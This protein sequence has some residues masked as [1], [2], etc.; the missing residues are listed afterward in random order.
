MTK[1]KKPK[2]TQTIKV[3][4]HWVFPK[5]VKGREPKAYYV[6][7]YKYE[8]KNKP[9]ASSA[10][11]KKKTL[12]PKPIRYVNGKRYKLKER[13]HSVGSEE[14]VVY[15]YKIEALVEYQRKYVTDYSL[16]RSAVGQNVIEYY[17]TKFR[18]TIK[19]STRLF[20]Q[21]I[22]ILRSYGH[23]ITFLAI[24]LYRVWGY[25]PLSEQ[26]WRLLKSFKDRKSVV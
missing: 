2:T 15:T 14:R 19:E 25:G 6:K 26:H 21:E 18:P 24:D 8:R 7:A 17:H 23:I 20:H 10:P 5:P 11:K 9:K 1:P 16:D 22:A 3:P 13:I 4:A 12:G